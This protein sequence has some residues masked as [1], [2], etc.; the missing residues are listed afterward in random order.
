M[1]VVLAEA[2]WVDDQNGADHFSPHF[3][4]C[5]NLSTPHFYVTGLLNYFELQIRPELPKMNILGFYSRFLEAGCPFCCT[6]NDIRALK[7]NVTLKWVQ[8]S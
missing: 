4:Y 8:F 5:S 2:G 6:T 7:G 1:L 3:W